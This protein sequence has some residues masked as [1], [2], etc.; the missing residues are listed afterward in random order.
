MQ[1]RKRIA[2]R[3]KD[4]KIKDKDSI[5]RIN[6]ENSCR[7]KKWLQS[8]NEDDNSKTNRIINSYDGKY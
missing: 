5:N 8:D 4:S 3:G 2:K 1:V 7:N 6:K